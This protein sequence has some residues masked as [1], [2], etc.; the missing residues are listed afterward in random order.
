M[1]TIKAFGE[2]AGYRAITA[3]M[4]L[5]NPV[6]LKKFLDGHGLKRDLE[7]IRD[8]GRAAEAHNTTQSGSQAGGTAATKSVA[9]A[10]MNLRGNYKTLFDALVA[11]EADLKED[12]AS[13]EVIARLVKIIKNEIPVVQ[14][15][16]ED[17]KKVMVRS[18]SQENWRAEIEKD[19]TAV[20]EFNEIH[21]QLEERQVKLESIKKMKKDAAG[22]SGKLAERAVKKGAAKTATKEER[23]AVKAQKARWAAVWRILEAVSRT[24]PGLAEMLKKASG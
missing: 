8:E 4:V 14:R 17:G 24:E 12:G 11:V 15:T 13:D 2:K 6:M 18:E 7:R 22:L 16:G 5:G 21:P 23:D 3:E 10:F 20:I 1:A 9:L 19:A